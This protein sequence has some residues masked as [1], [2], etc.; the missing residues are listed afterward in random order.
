MTEQPL[1]V[2]VCVCAHETK[3]HSTFHGY[4]E[5]L[6]RPKK[7]FS[8]VKASRNH[9]ELHREL[10]ITYKWY[11]YGIPLLIHNGADV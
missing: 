9:Q 2:C 11:L 10:L 1:C 4:Y 3:V 7:L 5:E 8:S 6:I